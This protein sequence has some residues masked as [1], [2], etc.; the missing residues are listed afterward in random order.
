MVDGGEDEPSPEDGRK[1][2][3][4]SSQEAG[5][6]RKADPSSHCPGQTMK[7]EDSL[8]ENSGSE[9]LC[10]GLLENSSDTAPPRDPSSFTDQDAGPGC[11][12]S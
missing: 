1:A 6:R 7:K 11:S 5:V 4:R 10:W 9:A 2:H 8:A 3:W 12:C